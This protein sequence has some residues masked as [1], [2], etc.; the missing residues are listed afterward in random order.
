MPTID[1]VLPAGLSE[2]SGSALK[3]C[4]LFLEALISSRAQLISVS[5]DIGNRSVQCGHSKL[6]EVVR[7]ILGAREFDNFVR[8]QLDILHPSSDANSLGELRFRQEGV[9]RKFIFSGDIR[10]AGWSIAVG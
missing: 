7:L 10:Q 9:D 2:A 6:R 8:Q 4:E 3:L 1:I 5:V